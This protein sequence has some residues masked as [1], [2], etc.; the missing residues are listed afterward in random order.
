MY[1]KQENR[2]SKSYQSKFQCYIS[3]NNQQTKQAQHLD[4]QTITEN[5]TL[6]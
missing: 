2:L 6:T 4:N 1:N 3:N 5:R